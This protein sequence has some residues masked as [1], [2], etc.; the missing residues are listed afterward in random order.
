VGL[1]GNAL[2]VA[3]AAAEG[4]SPPPALA[5]A[6]VAAFVAGLATISYFFNELRK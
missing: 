6:A 2:S 3:L 1:I 4:A 5:F